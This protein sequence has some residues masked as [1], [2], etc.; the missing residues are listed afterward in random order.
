MDDSG[1]SVPGARPMRGVLGSQRRWAES[2]LA[3]QEQHLT[4]ARAALAELERL[5]AALVAD[6]ADSGPDRDTALSAS[7]DELTERIRELGGQL[8]A[9]E[10]ARVTARTQ[11]LGLRQAEDR[12]GGGL[13]FQAGPLPGVPF[14]AA[15]EPPPDH[16]A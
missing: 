8:A 5:H 2:A 13:P 7:A 12:A 14:G 11:A 6:A 9:V 3:R 1:E 15:G 16:R 4:T 10:D